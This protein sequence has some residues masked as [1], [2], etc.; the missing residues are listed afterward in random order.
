VLTDQWSAAS[1]V[2]LPFPGFTGTVVQAM[3][4]YPQFTGITQEFA[5]FG[6]SFYNS[7]QVQLTRHFRRGLSVLGAYTWS[8]AIGFNDSAIDSETPADIYN[9]GLERA[10][11]RY[12]I[13]HFFK[14]SWVYELPIGP[15]KLVNVPGLAGKILGGWQLT[16]I[17]NISSGSPLSIG[18]GAISNPFGAARLDLVPGQQIIAN[19]NAPINFRGFVGGTPY[20]NRAAFAL[21][22]VHPG[23]RNVLQRLGT[24]GPMLPN[25][26][27]PHSVSEDLGV[28]KLFRVDE[29]RTVEIR[30]VFLNPFNR[31]GRG[32]LVTDFSNP[33][34]GQLTGQQRGG[35]N[36]EL[37]A[38][39]T[40]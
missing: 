11:T 13:P 6:T 25:I 16:G 20:L 21:P 9:R 40:F 7:M 38:R 24:L 37:S 26:R 32:G 5:N 23:G 27:G 35:R 19:S 30:G 18:G 4:P 36:I 31:V 10:I 33:F 28:W 15:N 34:F 1:G 17:H 12:H 29:H 39:V 3:R 8:K 22:P 2:P 14:L